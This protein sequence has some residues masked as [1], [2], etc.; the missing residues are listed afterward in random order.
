MTVSEWNEPS[1]GT[2]RGTLVVLPGRGETAAAYQR[3]PT[4]QRQAKPRICGGVEI[5]ETG[6]IGQVL[7]SIRSRLAA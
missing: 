7:L 4:R 3:Q 1:G 6:V 5:R 2:P